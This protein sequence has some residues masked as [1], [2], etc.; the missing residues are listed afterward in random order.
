MLLVILGFFAIT[1][2]NVLEA[3]EQGNRNIAEDIAEFAFREIEIAK[4]VNNGY[5]RIFALPQ[6]INGVNYSIIIIDDRELI[7]D[8]LGNEHV[9]FLP[10]NV[11]GNISKGSI[12]IEKI[13]DV[14]YLRS[15]AECSDKIDNDLDGSIDLT[16]AGCTD[17]SDNDET[18]CGD[19]ACEGPESCS[20]CSSD[21]GICPLPGNFF[22]K[23]LANVFSIDHTGNAILSGTL[24]KNTNPVPTGDDEFIFK[25]NGG[26]N[27]AIINLIT[28]N[29]VI[30]GQLFENQTALNPA[31]GNDVIIRDSNGAV[32]SYLDVSGDFYLKGTLTENGNP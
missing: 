3:K 8:Y 24:Q 12:L 4:S 14:V 28:G 11:T 2:S 32:V 6:T 15:I 7:V 26:N 21:C 27:R 30:Q 22:L 13:E 23:G 18:N 10:A 19:S 1:S 16:D 31:S 29:M 17:K 20:S 25:D 9:K 5:S